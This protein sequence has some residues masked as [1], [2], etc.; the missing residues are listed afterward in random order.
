MSYISFNSGTQEKLNNTALVD[1]LIYFNTD[2]QSMVVV[3]T[4]DNAL[5]PYY[6]NNFIINDKNFNGINDGNSTYSIDAIESLFIP[7]SKLNEYC[8]TTYINNAVGQNTSNT[9]I[10]NQIQD[11]YN[12]S[13]FK[14]D[15]SAY[16]VT[17]EEVYIEWAWE[18]ETVQ[19]ITI[20]ASR[21]N[22]NT[23]FIIIVGNTINQDE[24]T[25]DYNNVHEFM[26]IYNLESNDGMGFRY[27]STTNTYIKESSLEAVDEEQIYSIF[28]I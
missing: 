26:S 7:T 19:T 1:G 10:T 20:D 6:Y 18:Y 16:T 13:I 3:N 12:G 14:L 4:E 2:A 22:P 23:K 8:T 17:V 15:D 5:K 9:S 25:I 27:D 24:G 21:L 11:I 28:V